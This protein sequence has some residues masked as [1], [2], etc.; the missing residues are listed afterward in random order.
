[1]WP[2]TFNSKRKRHHFLTHHAHKDHSTPMGFPL[3]IPRFV[4]VFTFSHFPEIPICFYLFLVG[5]VQL[6]VQLDDH[7]LWELRLFYPQVCLCF[8]LSLSRFLM[9]ISALV[10]LINHGFVEIVLLLDISYYTHDFFVIHVWFY[11]AFDFLLGYFFGYTSYF[12]I[13]M[14]YWVGKHSLNC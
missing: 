10:S 2:F 4:S 12:T 14:I 9:P 1:M 6:F 7:Y 8:P 5:F 13:C 3:T 11:F